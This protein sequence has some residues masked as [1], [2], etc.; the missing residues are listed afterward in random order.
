M[1][2]EPQ[3][4]THSLFALRAPLAPSPP[5]LSLSLSLPPKLPPTPSL[6]GLC[7]LPL[8]ACFPTVPRITPKSVLSRFM[9]P[10]RLVARG[11]VGSPTLGPSGGTSPSKRGRSLGA[12]GR[13]QSYGPTGAPP[14][15]SLGSRTLSAD[16]KRRPVGGLAT[17]SVSVRAAPGSSD[18]AGGGAGAGD[19][20]PR[21]SPQP[22][23]LL[24]VE[25]GRGSESLEESGWVPMYWVGGG[26]SLPFHGKATQC[27]PLLPPPRPLSV[28]LRMYWT[29]ARLSARTASQCTLLELPTPLLSRLAHPPSPPTPPPTHHHHPCPFLL[30]PCIPGRNKRS[31]PSGPLCCPHP[32]PSSSRP[33]SPHCPW[34]L[35]RSWT[36]V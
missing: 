29:L 31:W 26:V 30:P 15:V 1:S 33:W 20:G 17:K 7:P 13:A 34:R 24:P 21:A 18:G 32:L 11:R 14:S 4:H 8:Q 28:S 2:S 23:P 3:T 9:V 6:S 10:E 22:L 19:K 25:E 16:S 36:A 12:V 5:P 27:S 35:Y